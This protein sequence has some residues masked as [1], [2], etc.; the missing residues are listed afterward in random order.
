MDTDRTP[1]PAQSVCECVCVCTCVCVSV[2][3]VEGLQFLSTAMPVSYRNSQTYMY[4]A[5]VHA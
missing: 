4:T 2:G 1:R 3:G 5:I